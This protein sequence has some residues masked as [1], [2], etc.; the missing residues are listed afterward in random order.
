MSIELDYMEYPNDPAAQVAY[1]T[2][3]CWDILDENCSDISDWNDADFDTAVSEVDPAGQF[4]FDTNKGAAGNAYV[5]RWR[6]LASP[7]TRFT[8]EIKTYFDAIGTRTNLDCTRLIY[9]KNMGGGDI[10]WFNSYFTSDGLYITKAGPIDAEIGTDLVKHGGSAAW[11]IW[12]FEFDLSTYTVE[13]FLDGVSQGTYDCDYIR[14]DGTDG[15]IAFYQYGYTTDDIVSHYDW[16]KIGAAN[17]QCFSE[18]TIKQQGSYSLRGV[19]KITGSLNDTLTRTVSPTIDLTDI[20][21]IKLDIRSS[22]TG[23]NIKVGIHDSGG[24]TTEIT[25]NI[26]SA[27]AWQT[28]EWDISAVANADKDAI[29]QI[30]ITIVNADADNNAYLDNMFGSAWAKTFLESI[31]LADTLQKKPAKTF[32][33]SITLTDIIKKAASKILS[34]TITLSDSLIKKTYKTF[35]ES[36]TLTDVYSR[37]WNIYRTF[38][39]TLNLTDTLIKKPIKTFVESLHL[40][41]TLI[42]KPAK[43]F[44]ETLSL[45]D[46]LRK[47]AIKT[48]SESLT[49]SDTVRKRISKTFLETLHLQDSYTRVVTWYRTFTEKIT[50]TDTVIKVKSNLIGIWKKLMNLF[51]TEG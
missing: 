39:E 36:I 11:Q 44:S 49:L 32:L 25:P 7:P 40:T 21:K 41:D 15:Q 4:R 37:I 34:E 8:L 14:G 6:N 5:M 38:T 26:T 48:F 42:K 33:E 28:V 17:L 12:R 10:W 1:V 27:N 20:T 29:D 22:R 47:K 24:T 31:T 13:V 43:V 46:T 35:T 18:A 50:L 30:I 2:S 19:A 23:S 45:S 16:I 9:I 3:D 51:D